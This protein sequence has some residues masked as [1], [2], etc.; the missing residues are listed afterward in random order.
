MHR[1]WGLIAAW[2]VWRATQQNRRQPLHWSVAQLLPGILHALAN[3]GQM[4]IPRNADIDN[5]GAISATEATF[6]LLSV[7]VT[8]T[9]WAIAGWC[10][11]DARRTRE[12]AHALHDG[13][14]STCPDF[15]TFPV[16]DRISVPPSSHVLRNAQH[17]KR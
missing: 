9:T 16:I 17:A 4:E 11:I 10:L 1:S 13:R 7:L 6:F 2:H 14:Y 5:E 8:L 3:T 12:S 15:P